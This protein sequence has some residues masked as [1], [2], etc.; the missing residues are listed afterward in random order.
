ML[1]GFCVFRKEPTLEEVR[2]FLANTIA[3][4]ARQPRH[5]I[6]DQGKQFSDIFTD[7]CKSRSPKINP[8]QGA[9]GQHG[10]IAIIE[11]FIR[12]MKN[13]VFAHYEASKNIDKFRRE[14]TFYSTWYNQYRTHQGIEGRY[15]I[16]VYLGVQDIVPSIDTRAKDAKPLILHVAYLENRKHLPIVELRQAA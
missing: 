2:I 16:D 9:V 15:P 14:L 10:S 4:W 6:S 12:S 3:S 1:L 11:R 13:E 7:W 8:R 5:L